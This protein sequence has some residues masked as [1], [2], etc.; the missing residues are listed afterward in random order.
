MHVARLNQINNE[1][2]NPSNVSEILIGFSELKNYFAEDEIKSFSTFCSCQEIGVN[3]PV[4]SEGE[5]ADCLM[6]VIS[7]RARVISEGIQ[8]GSIEVG[9]F[10][11][12]GM[13]SSEDVRSASVESRRAIDCC[14]IY[15]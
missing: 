14:D 8:I 1:S 10:V 13:F 3:A 2:V 5:P 12:E 9:D 11:G 15:P 7:G 4:M 6:Y